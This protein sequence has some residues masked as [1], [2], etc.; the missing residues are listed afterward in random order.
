MSHYKILLI[1]NSIIIEISVTVVVVVVVAVT[2][3]FCYFIIVSTTAKPLL[4][5]Q[6]Q[7]RNL[8]ACHLKQENT[9]SF[10]L[11]GNHFFLPQ[12]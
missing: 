3:A 8:S 6:Y 11:A 7:W 10:Q 12:G 5:G 4:I 9:T 1:L 2:V